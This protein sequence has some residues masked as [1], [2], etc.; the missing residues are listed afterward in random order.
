M[1]TKQ[2]DQGTTC[3]LKSE[4]ELLIKQHKILKSQ[5]TPVSFLSAVSDKTTFNK[6][7]SRNGKD[8]LEDC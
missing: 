8:Q 1:K 3:K 6:K 5:E 7:L 4:R 2:K